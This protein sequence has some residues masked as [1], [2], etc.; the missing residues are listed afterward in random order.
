MR[1]SGPSL[2]FLAIIRPEGRW[3]T[4]K[5]TP[6]LPAPS[7]QIFSKSSS[8]SSP[9]F[10]FCVRKASRRFRC[11]SSSSSSSSFFCSASKF[12]LTKS[13]HIHG[14][15]VLS[16]GWLWAAWVFCRQELEVEEAGDTE[17][18]NSLKDT[19]HNMQE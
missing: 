13:L 18:R 5:T 14:D 6:P 15:A 1:P 17:K 11:C 4:L 8:F 10:C 16:L 9:T 12:V 19:P 2:T 7:S 3:E